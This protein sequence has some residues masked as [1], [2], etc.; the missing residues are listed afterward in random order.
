MYCEK[1]AHG[2]EGLIGW[3]RYDQAPDVRRRPGMLRDGLLRAR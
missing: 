3:S 1:A 2:G